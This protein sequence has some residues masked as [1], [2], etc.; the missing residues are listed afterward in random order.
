VAHINQTISFRGMMLVASPALND[1]FFAR[2][3]VYICAHDSDGAI[4]IVLNKEVGSIQMKELL[5]GQNIKLSNIPKRKCPLLIGGPLNPEQFF[6]LSML[7]NQEANFEQAH[8]LTFHSNID[9]FIQDYIESN[10]NEKFVV[11]RGIT[12][13]DPGQLEHEIEENSWFVEPADEK[14]IFSQRIKDKWQKIIHKIGVDRPSQNI[15][16]Y[17][18][19]A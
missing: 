3:I 5:A 1:S 8:A 7:P 16:H 14:I 17:S 6:T 15:V 13:W 2:T 19:S 10:C 4:G 12:M 18:G 9:T 11:A